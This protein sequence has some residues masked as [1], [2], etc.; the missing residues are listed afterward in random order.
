L[1]TNTVPIRQNLSG[2]E[3]IELVRRVFKSEA[4]IV[5]Y[6]RFPISEL[7]TI[8]GGQILFET[9]FNFTHFYL[10]KT[11]PRISGARIFD[12]KVKGASNYVFVTDCNQDIA[13]SQFE[14]AFS[15]DATLVDF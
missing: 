3:W 10:Y 2:G 7:K 8:E 1:F 12:F 9:M 6:R 5:P 15:Y 13:S 11:V 14:L 4:D